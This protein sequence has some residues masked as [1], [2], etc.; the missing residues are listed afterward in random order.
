MVR[1]SFTFEGKRY[2]IKAKT[3]RE[4]FEKMA[5][6]R[7]DLEE[8]RTIIGKNTPVSVWAERWF[9]TY[10]KNSVSES[11][12]SDIWSIMNS[13]ILPEIGRMPIKQVKPIHLQGVLNAKKGFSL[14]YLKKIKIVMNEMF[15][16]AKRNNLILENPCEALRLPVA[17]KNKKRRSL[18]AYETKMVLKAAEGFR[19]GLYY[20]IMLYCGLRPG[21]AAALQ[22]LFLFF[23]FSPKKSIILVKIRKG[24][25]KSVTLG[26]TLNHFCNKK[27]TPEKNRRFYAQRADDLYFCP[28]RKLEITYIL[29]PGSPGDLLHIFFSERVCI[30]SI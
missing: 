20:K 4:A 18:T 26:V 15:D 13:C 11:W 24:H 23:K 9:E 14:S 30:Y 10:K 7:R 6:K 27:I 5:L 1:K 25:A 22:W 8:G 21:E 3:E 16:A 12:G 19:G 29:T 17:R 28:V 2:F